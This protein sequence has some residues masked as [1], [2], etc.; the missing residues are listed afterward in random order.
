MTMSFT[1]DRSTSNSAANEVAETSVHTRRRVSTADRK[2]QILD[3]AI[4]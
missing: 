1:L 4:Q 3:S 2:S